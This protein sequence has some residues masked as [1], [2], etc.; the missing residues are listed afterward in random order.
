MTELVDFG[1]QPVAS[2]FL[3]DPC[4]EE[5]LFPLVL[6][7]CPGC[8]LVQLTQSPPFGELTPRYPWISYREPEPHLDALADAIARLP[9]VSWDAPIWGVSSKDDTL[10][11]RMAR[12]GFRDTYRL[13]LRRDLDC[14]IPFAGVETVQDRLTPERVAALRVSRRAPQVIVARHILEHAHD[15][16]GF[17]EA[18]AGLLAPEGY[19]VLEVPDCRAGFAQ[20]DYTTVWEEHIAYFTPA[21]FPMVFEHVAQAMVRFQSVPYR[22]ESVLIGIGRAASS[23]GAAGTRPLPL[24]ADDLAAIQAFGGKLDAERRRLSDLLASRRRHGQAIAILGAGHRACAFVNFLGL[25]DHVSF[26]VDDDPRKQGLFM[27]G[28]RLPIRG[29]QTLIEENVGLCLLSVNPEVEEHVVDKNRAFVERGG[30][31]ASIFA[32]SDRSMTA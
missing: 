6:A 15:L 19:L 17:L 21:T 9:G 27:P 11:E 7:Q 4:E 16:Q 13:D 30:Q 20:C 22:Q 3:A 32:V 18:L 14:Q 2:R 12:L 1:R 10:L 5:V 28:S 23:S 24:P 29:S 8:G 31:F 25:R 26:V